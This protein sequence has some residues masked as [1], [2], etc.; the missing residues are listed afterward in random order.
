M[1]K[2]EQLQVFGEGSF[3]E[4]LKCKT[5]AT[6]EIVAIKRFKDPETDDC[7]RTLIQREIQA[8]E[9]LRG[10]PNVVQMKEWFRIKDTVYLVFEF[11]PNNMLEI[12][13]ENPKGM[14]T[15]MIRKYLYQVVSAIAACHKKG[16]LH[17]DVK[18]ENILVNKAQ[19]QAYLCDF[20]CARKWRAR[21]A[22]TLYIATRWYRAPELILGYEY[23]GSVDMWALGCVMAEM[24][25]GRPLIPCKNNT[26]A[27][28]FIHATVGPLSSQQVKDAKSE[29]C[30]P[31]L[32]LPPPRNQLES[33]FSKYTDAA[34][35]DFLQQLLRV[36][37]SKR[38]TA[39]QALKHPYFASLHKSS[40]TAPTTTTRASAGPS[41][42]VPASVPGAGPPISAAS[43]APL[44]IS[45]VDMAAGY[46]STSPTQSQSLAKKP[47]KKNRGK[48]K[49]KA[50]DMYLE[51]DDHSTTGLSQFG[52]SNMSTAVIQPQPPSVST[53]TKRRRE[54]R[55]QAKL[56]AQQQAQQIQLMNEGFGAG[57]GGGLGHSGGHGHGHYGHHA[58]QGFPS[59]HQQTMFP[60]QH[61]QGMYSNNWGHGSTTEHLPMLGA[62]MRSTQQH[63]DPLDSI[64]MKGKGPSPCNVAPPPMAS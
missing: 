16:I 26:H 13:Q 31:A 36:E 48:G 43:P 60:H 44:S 33:L 39:E 25:T 2:Y 56:R 42:P 6:G 30:F 61:K 54:R 40:T 49:N 58:P 22:M 18:P 63:H 59:H 46:S 45:G 41:V 23:D 27:L 12:M 55:K 47:K 1:E 38:M 35:M 24:L 51:K 37:A 3:G 64:S 29:S 52:G 4:V 32:Q 11:I 57:M 28:Q 14:P 10:E 19:E 34:A 7:A 9:D 20:G 62:G 15:E 53:P 50:E 17:R 21:L 8:L 5:K